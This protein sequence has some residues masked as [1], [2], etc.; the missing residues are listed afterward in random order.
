MEKDYH[1]ALEIIHKLSQEDYE[2]FI[3][4]FLEEIE[5]INK[6]EKLTKRPLWNGFE[7]SEYYKIRGYRKD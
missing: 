4:N 6:R 5:S 7:L 1:E 3:G 2:L